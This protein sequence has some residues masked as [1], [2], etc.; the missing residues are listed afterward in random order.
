MTMEKK[1]S[2]TKQCTNRYT[3]RYTKQCNTNLADP[4]GGDIKKIFLNTTLNVANKMQNHYPK[5]QTQNPKNQNNK[6]NKYSSN[7]R[8]AYYFLTVL[9]FGRSPEVNARHISKENLVVSTKYI[10]LKESPKII[11]LKIISRTRIFTTKN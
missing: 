6:N 2:K 4:G 5:N 10:R 11:P 9:H 3:N 7:K 1:I 8:L